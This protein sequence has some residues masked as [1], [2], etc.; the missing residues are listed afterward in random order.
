MSLVAK[1]TGMTGQQT[2]ECSVTV[3][4]GGRLKIEPSGDL[5]AFRHMQLIYL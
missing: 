4:W 5:N 2:S 1:G 3:V